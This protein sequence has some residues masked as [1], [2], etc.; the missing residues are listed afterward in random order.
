MAQSK[1]ERELASYYGNV[2]GEQRHREEE[3]DG[4]MRQEGQEDVF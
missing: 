3:C 2:G 4:R 1:A